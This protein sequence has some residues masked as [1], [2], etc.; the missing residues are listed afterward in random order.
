MLF[1]RFIGKRPAGGAVSLQHYMRPFTDS[2]VDPVQSNLIIIIVTQTHIMTCT[3]LM[4][5]QINN[6]EV[7]YA[8]MNLHKQ[9]KIKY[10]H[11][12]SLNHSY[13]RD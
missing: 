3:T 5:A 2:S 8:C 1:E 13:P 10:V 12:D 9:F 4:H 11:N 7:H 6:N